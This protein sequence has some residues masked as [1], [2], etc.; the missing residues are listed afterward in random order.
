MYIS[1]NKINNN[2]IDGNNKLEIG[3]PHNDT[4]TSESRLNLPLLYKKFDK[5]HLSLLTAPIFK[6]VFVTRDI[7]V[8]SF[9]IGTTL[10]S[11]H[12]LKFKDPLRS[13]DICWKQE[14][15]SCKL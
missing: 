4:V 14:N 9:I 2:K 3:Q 1:K 6:V 8:L 10:W 7:L 11:S 13:V 15:W 5:E 12:K